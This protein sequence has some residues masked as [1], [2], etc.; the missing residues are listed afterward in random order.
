MTFLVDFSATI[1]VE[2]PDY[3]EAEATAMEELREFIRVLQLREVAVDSVR[4][5]KKGQQ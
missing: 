1:P 5:E 2:A 4:R 3:A